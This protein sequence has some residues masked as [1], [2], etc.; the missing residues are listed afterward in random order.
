MLNEWGDSF[1][2]IHV[3]T[4]FSRAAK[5][6]GKRPQ[7]AW[8]LADQL[9]STWHTDLPNAKARALATVLWA[10]SKIQFMNAQLWAGTLEAFLQP[11]NLSEADP[12]HLSNTAYALA[13]V[14]T[15]NKGAVPGLQ[16]EEVVDAVQ[17]LASEMYVRVTNPSLEVG[18]T[19]LSSFIWACAKLQV[20]PDDVEMRALLQSFA[21]PDV[22]G[23]ADT[24]SISLVLYA[25]SELAKVSTTWQQSTSESMWGHLLG[26]MSLAKVAQ[27]GDPQHVSNMLLALARLAS[28]SAVPY[29][30]QGYARNCAEVL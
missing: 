1:D 13:M 16:R 4:A 22:I 9:A 21:R 15:A 11:R 2:T 18:P 6:A 17:Q 7:T 27:Y 20:A 8:R 10:S 12:V 3:V 30:T 23:A 14:C 25:V 19:A 24:Q 29:I 5:V 26:E 28:T